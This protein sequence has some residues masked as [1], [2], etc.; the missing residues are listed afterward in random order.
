[1]SIVPNILFLDY[2]NLSLLIILIP[3]LDNNTQTIYFWMSFL[4]IMTV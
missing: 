2:F 4:D 3:D 1:M